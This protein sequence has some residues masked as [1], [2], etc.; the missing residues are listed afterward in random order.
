MTNPTDP[1]KDRVLAEIREKRI[2]MRPKLSFTFETFFAALVALVVLAVSAALASFIVFGLRVNGHDSLLAFGP[3]GIGA[4]LLIFPW[5]LLILNILLVI[6]LE[7]LLRRFKF[8]YRSPV[9]YL[10]LA[11]AALAIA[12][13]LALDRTSVND[14]LLDRADRGALPSPFAELYEHVRSPAPHDRGIYR[15]MVTAIGTSTFTMMHDDDD[16]DLD[17]GSYT[18]AFPPGFPASSL[19]VG[20]RVYVAGDEDDGMIRAFGVNPLPVR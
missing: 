8:G 10:L 20:E 16:Q 13:G 11:L 4:F 14:D 18:V 9:L 19:T 5:P 6:F 3:R 17:E 15:G 1:I 12:A 7:T 2:A